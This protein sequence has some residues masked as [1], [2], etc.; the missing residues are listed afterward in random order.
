ME[1]FNLK[2]TKFLV[3]NTY[4]PNSCKGG[5][6]VINYIGN[7]ILTDVLQFSPAFI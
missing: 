7:K 1:L 5:V 2:S 6:K 4:G 3:Y